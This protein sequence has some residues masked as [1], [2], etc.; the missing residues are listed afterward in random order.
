[1]HDAWTHLMIWCRMLNI[2]SIRRRT[3]LD[4]AIAEENWLCTELLLQ[5]GARFT[6]LN[7]L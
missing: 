5:A 6:T 7:S 2:S 1:M 3:P 4:D